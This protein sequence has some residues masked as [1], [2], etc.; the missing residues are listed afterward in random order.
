MDRQLVKLNTHLKQLPTVWIVQRVLDEIAH[1]H[2]D[3]CWWFRV[4]FE[5]VRRGARMCCV[6]GISASSK[7]ISE[8]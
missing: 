6:L 3:T 1:E 2:L 8:L 7:N 5:V 4:S